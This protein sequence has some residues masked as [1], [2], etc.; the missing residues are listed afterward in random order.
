M[1][2]LAAAVAAAAAASSAAPERL[3][4]SGPHCAGNR[5]VLDRTVIIVTVVSVFEPLTP[6]SGTEAA[7][8]SVLLRRPDADADAA[9]LFDHMK[10]PGA[11]SGGSELI[12]RFPRSENQAALTDQHRSARDDCTRSAN[13]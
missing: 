2:L 4:L 7:A 13:R 5:T 11:A 8:R 6:G 9:H 12:H 1:L 10:R 3:L